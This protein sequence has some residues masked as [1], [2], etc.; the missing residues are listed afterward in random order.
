MQNDIK[1]EKVI[2]HRDIPE[3][4]QLAEVRRRHW[5]VTDITKSALSESS[6]KAHHLV[7]LSSLDEDFS[8]EEIQVIWEIEPAQKL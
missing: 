1:K 8:C 7:S 4:G 3:P 5:V 2:T 6:R